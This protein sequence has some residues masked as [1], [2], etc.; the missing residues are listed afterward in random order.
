[1]RHE[2]RL[3]ALLEVPI[4][5]N[6]V[7]RCR[8]LL[9]GFLHVAK[10]VGLD[11][12]IL[13]LGAS[14]GFNLRWDKYHYDFGGVNWGDASAGVTIAGNRSDAPPNLDVKPSVV[15]RSGCDLAPLDPNNAKDAT[16]LRSCIWPDDVERARLLEEAIKAHALAE[17]PVLV[18]KRSAQE[19]LENALQNPL[20]DVATVVFNSFVWC[21]IEP[22]EKARILTLFE[23]RGNEASPKSPL[24]WL[25]LEW[26]DQQPELRVIVWPGG[27]EM[28]LATCDLMGRGIVWRNHLKFDNV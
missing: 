27:Q 10:F 20:R 11:L 8:V 22:A 7:G 25:R 1:M 28:T 13:E 24:A 2:E 4:Q 15:H 3:R 16:I 19:W 21:Y 5:T 12:R 14:A 9:G 6:E 18:E 17:T 23:A 26:F